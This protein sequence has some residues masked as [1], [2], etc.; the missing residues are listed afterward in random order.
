MT[1]KKE[2]EAVSTL[3][4]VLSILGLLIVSTTVVLVVEY[5]YNEIKAMMEYENEM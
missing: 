1:C 3:F 2:E 4:V 5:L